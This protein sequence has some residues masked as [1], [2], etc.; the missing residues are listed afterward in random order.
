MNEPFLGLLTGFLLGFLMQKGGVLRFDRQIG[1]LMFRDMTVLK[2]MLTAILVGSVGLQLMSD[3]HVIKLTHLPVNVG[4]LVVGGLLFGIGWAIAGYC[5]GT[6]IGALA[7]GRWM[8]L[9]VV[10]GMLVGAALYAEAYPLLKA[11][12]LGWKDYGKIDLP[13]ALRVSPWMCIAGLWGAG[14][15]AFVWCEFKRV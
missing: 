5:P 10:A 3:A 2:F 11:T 9:F 7:E 6:E 13:H 1:L 12:V 8:A 15:V 14:I 4:G